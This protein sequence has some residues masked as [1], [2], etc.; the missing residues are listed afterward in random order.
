VVVPDLETIAKLY[1]ESLDKA[2]SGDGSA[3]NRHEWM[4]LELLDQMVRETSGGEMGRYFQL[5]PMPAED[6]VIT[7][8]GN[9]VLEV[10]RPLRANPALRNRPVPPS[11]RP[12]D[13]MEAARFR[14]SGEIHKWMYDRRSLG[15]LLAESGLERVEVKKA[16]ESSIP[17]FGTYLLDRMP[18]GSTRKPDSLFMESF[19]P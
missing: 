3:S 18:D 14:Q 7:R 10:I 2:E 9:Q 13:A 19:K 12:I 17:E 8:L 4:L 6:F 16:W 5:N 15:K 1:L 11:P